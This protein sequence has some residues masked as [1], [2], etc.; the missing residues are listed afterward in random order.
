MS[1]YL[2]AVRRRFWTASQ[3]HKELGHPHPT[4][5]LEKPKRLPNT[6]AAPSLNSSSS[7][8]LPGYIALSAAQLQL[9][10]E[11]ERGELPTW[12]ARLMNKPGRLALVKSILKVIPVHQLFVLTPR[13]KIFKQL[14]RVERGYLWAGREDANGGNCHVNWRRVCRPILVG[15]LGVRDL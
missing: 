6:L 15:E 9:L 13:K 7:N 12:K 1:R 2:A 14:E 11:K 10:I 4:V 8:W 3:L 5:S